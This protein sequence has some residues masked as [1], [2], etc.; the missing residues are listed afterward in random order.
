[1]SKTIKAEPNSNGLYKIFRNSGYNFHTACFE[2]VDNSFH[3]NVNCTFHDTSVICDPISKDP[4]K[5]CFADDGNSMTSDI[6]D[7]YF[8]IGDK[9]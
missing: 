5:I 8:S 6:A 9:K 7:K 1:M 4:I 2:F 3:R